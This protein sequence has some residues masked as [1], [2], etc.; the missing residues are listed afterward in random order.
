MNRLVRKYVNKM[1][2]HVDG[3][4]FDVENLMSLLTFDTILGR[5]RIG[6]GRGALASL[7]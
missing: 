2:E 3:P 6:H 7:V 4:Q 1:E 5:T